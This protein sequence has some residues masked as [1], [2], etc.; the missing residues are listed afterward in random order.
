MK[1]GTAPSL[2]RT[3]RS[4]LGALAAGSWVPLVL[5][6]RSK[7]DPRILFVLTVVGIL[8]TFTGSTLAV[9]NPRHDGVGAAWLQVGLICGWIGW[10]YLHPATGVVSL[11]LLGFGLWIRQRSRAAEAEA[12]QETFTSDQRTSTSTYVERKA[13]MGE[14]WEQQ[15]QAKREL[16]DPFASPH[17]PQP[18]ENGV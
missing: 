18:D 12:W 1:T 6:I 4:L 13:G 16:A 7:A 8:I 10:M 9:M 15:Q 11:P 5:G 14:R 2:R 3:A 17:D